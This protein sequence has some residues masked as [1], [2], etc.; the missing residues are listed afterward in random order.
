MRR[1]CGASE[2]CTML[3]VPWRADNLCALS[4]DMLSRVVNMQLTR[5]Y[6]KSGPLYQLVVIAVLVNRQSTVLSCPSSPPDRAVISRFARFVRLAVCSR[7]D[8]KRS[9]GCRLPI[10]VSLPAHLEIS[11]RQRGRQRRLPLLLHSCRGCV[12]AFSL[13]ASRLLRP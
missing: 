12:A 7:L 4:S 1:P 11:C 9:L 5:D 3:S 8:S 10:G 2:V 13:V 6:D